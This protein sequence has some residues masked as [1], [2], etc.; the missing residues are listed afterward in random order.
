MRAGPRDPEAVL[1]HTQDEDY[2][3]D[4]LQEG[5]QYFFNVVPLKTESDS[6]NAY[7]HV[8]RL[9]SHG[10]IMFLSQEAMRG[11]GERQ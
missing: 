2:M 4:W 1:R 5:S 6:W 9:L 11:V 7:W 3:V 10:G 8:F